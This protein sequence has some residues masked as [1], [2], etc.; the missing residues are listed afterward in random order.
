MAV[1]RREIA[2][3]LRHLAGL[4]ETNPDF[5]LSQVEALSDSLFNFA[6]TTEID[7]YIFINLDEVVNQLYLSMQNSDDIRPVG[8]PSY[9]LPMDAVESYLLSGLT[10]N[11]IASLFGVGDR[12]VHRRLADHGMR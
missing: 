5:V 3:Q 6:A 7:P 12:T 8:R 10:V 2:R 1:Y 9:F 11:N 4:A